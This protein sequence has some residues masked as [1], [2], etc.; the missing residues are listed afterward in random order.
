MKIWVDD[1]RPVPEDFDVWCKTVPQFIAI[2]SHAM[3]VKEEI[4][5]VSLDHDA[6]DYVKYGGDYID[7][8]EWLEKC[9]FKYG[10]E[11]CKR[12][13]LHTGNPV[14]RENMRRIIKH[15]GW[16]EVEYAEDFF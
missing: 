11:P 7:C 8:L 3:G 2:V 1:I 6:G 10:L 15:C 9:K 4:E 12:F 5:L 13:Y 14:G 16:E